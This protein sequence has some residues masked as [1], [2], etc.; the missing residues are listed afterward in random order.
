M[1]ANS[2]FTGFRPIDEGPDLRF[3]VDAANSGN[4][5]VGDL[6]KA[7]AAGSVN[8]GA[9]DDGNIIAGAVLA[10]YD[11][12]GIPVGT[13]GSSV[14]TKYLPTLT[15]GYALVA[16][17][18]EGRRFI[19]Q[20]DTVL[21]NAARL[22]T[23]NH[24][25]GSGNTT[26]ARSGQSINGNDLNTGAQVLILEPV[27]EPGND[28]TAANAGWVVIFNESIFMGVGKATGV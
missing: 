25:A 19:T 16:C 1:G 11:S 7:V 17:A 14:T 5:F 8:L 28:I 10:L 20:T 9:A 22:A 18:V 27:D 23:T 2:R 3:I 21:T 12:N 24:V 15:A 26:L 13:P 6:V 4:I